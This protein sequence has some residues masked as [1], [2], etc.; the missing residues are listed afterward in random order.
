MT[1]REAESRSYV[2]DYQ[3]V[4][5]GGF[6]DIYLALPLLGYSSDFDFYSGEPYFYPFLYSFVHGIHNEKISRKL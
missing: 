1:R 3:W 6:I 5:Y 2:Y 4:S